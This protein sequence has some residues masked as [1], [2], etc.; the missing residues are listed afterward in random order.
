VANP[1]L[2]AEI[3]LEASPLKLQESNFSADSYLIQISQFVVSIIM[4][5]F[6]VQTG[7][8]SQLNLFVVT[9]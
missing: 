9:K 8:L 5:R 1:N 3:K 6:S 2:S 4:V 7:V